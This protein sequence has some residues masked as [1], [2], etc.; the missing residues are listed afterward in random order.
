MPNPKT[1]PSISLSKNQPFDSLLM[2]ESERLIRNQNY[3]YDV[4]FFVELTS[5]QS[6]SVD[7]YIVELDSWSIIPNVMATPS[8]FTFDILE[9]NFGGL[10]NEFRNIYKWNHTKGFNAKLSN[11]YDLL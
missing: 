4:S 10:G 6:D 3:V 8:S 5:A 7:I 9:K 11:N 1:I 2:K